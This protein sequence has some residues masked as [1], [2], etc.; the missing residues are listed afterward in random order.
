MYIKC[1]VWEK[2]AS[3]LRLYRILWRNHTEKVS[4]YRPTIYPSKSTC[5][6]MY[7][8]YIY[9]S[10]WIRYIQNTSCLKLYVLQYFL[11]FLKIFWYFVLSDLTVLFLLEICTKSNDTR[12]YDNGDLRK[13]NI[14]LLY[15]ISF[16]CFFLLM[17]DSYFIMV[18]ILTCLDVRK[19]CWFFQH[20]N[21]EN[22]VFKIC[23]RQSVICTMTTQTKR[24]W[25]CLSASG[26]YN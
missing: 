6:Q 10:I 26:P 5:I 19:V 23:F 16:W 21:L 1:V 3:G 11:I 15:F 18:S 7:T 17:V 25:Y 13:N 2:I 12:P 22:C 14:W 9:I 20:G 24:K 4:E 8:M